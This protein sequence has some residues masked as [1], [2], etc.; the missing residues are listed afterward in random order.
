MAQP[1]PK[2]K[3]DA[4]SRSFY[5]DWTHTAEFRKNLLLYYIVINLAVSKGVL[6]FIK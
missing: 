6:F 2:V 5:E 4:T 1:S 3:V